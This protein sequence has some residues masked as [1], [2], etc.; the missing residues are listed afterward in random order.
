[1]NFFKSF[2]SVPSIAS[3]LR[4]VECLLHPRY[5]TCAHALRFCND[6][7]MAHYVKVP[8]RH[9]FIAQIVG[10]LV[11]SFICTGVMNFQMRNIP[12]VC[13]SYQ[14]NHFT[15]PGITTFQTAAVLWGTIGPIKVF[16]AGGQYT[17]LL[18]GFPIGFLLPIIAFYAKK[19]WPKARWL[20]FVHPVCIF[21]GPIQ[22]A[23]VSSHRILASPEPLSI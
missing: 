14:A 12:D 3:P 18:I 19:K 17:W 4:Q 11:S 23:P 20:R 10:T 7:K 15:C 9:T 13:E 22:W 16:G 2:G 5:V 1:M 21:K 8:P 6:L